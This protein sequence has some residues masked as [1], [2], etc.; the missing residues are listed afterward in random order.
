[1]LIGHPERY[2]DAQLDEWIR[3]LVDQSMPENRRLDYK[4]QPGERKEEWAKDITSFANELGGVLLYGIP[5]SR[6]T[7]SAPVPGRPYGIDPVSGFEQ[8]L[9]NV[10]SSAITPLLPTYHIRKVQLSEYPDKVCYVVWTPESWAGPHMVTAYQDHRFYRRGES[11]A[12]MMTERDVE[13]RY[14]RRLELRGVMEEFVASEDAW[15]NLSAFPAGVPATTIMVIPH[16]LIPNRIVFHEPPMQTWLAGRPL[17]GYW[18]PSMHGALM[19]S[20][21]SA[22]DQEIVEMH[23]NGAIVAHHRTAGKM[24][25]QRL[26]F[27]VA[28]ASEIYAWQQ[29][30]EVA[31]QLYQQIGY[32]GPVTI[33]A[34]LQFVKMI[35]TLTHA[36][37]GTDHL[38][39]ILPH[40]GRARLLSER[41]ER[42]IKLQVDSSA[43]ELALRPNKVLREAADELCRAFGRWQADCFDEQDRL[44]QG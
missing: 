22:D 40:G 6:N 3:R 27:E 33:V 23:R 8:D 32:D 1:M 20:Q 28:Y 44:V 15:H 26:R 11:R 2:T 30:L 18:L 38:R 36:V 24:D 4:A 9:E 10:Y 37:S 42:T 25:A 31:G 5:E 7:E 13:E 21:G 14:R 16:L 17:G 29:W 35:Y 41:S 43:S 19:T 34:A 12:L 39:F